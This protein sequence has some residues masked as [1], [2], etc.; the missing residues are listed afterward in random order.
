MS[1]CQRFLLT[2]VFGAAGFDKSCRT[3]KNKSVFIPAYG[4]GLVQSTLRESRFC[5]VTLTTFCYTFQT[6]GILGYRQRN[7]FVLF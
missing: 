7:N 2:G 1:Q 5:L 6:V 4:A 3:D